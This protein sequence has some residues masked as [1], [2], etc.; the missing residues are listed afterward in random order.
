MKIPSSIVLL[1][2]LTKFFIYEI[3]FT[4]DMLDFYPRFV[5]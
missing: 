1:G 4:F 2:L 3:S 5:Q